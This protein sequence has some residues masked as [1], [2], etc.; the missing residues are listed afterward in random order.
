MSDTCTW[1]TE[2]FQSA[3]FGLHRIAKIGKN[4]W[5][6]FGLTSLFK[7][8]SLEYII[9][10]SAQIDFEYL[11]RRRYSGAPILNF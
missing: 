3:L 11:K 2:R 8:D 4:Y 5:K 6:S 7:E 1:R 10:D 9:Q